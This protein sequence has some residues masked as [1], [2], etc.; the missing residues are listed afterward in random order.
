MRILCLYNNEC[1]L[2]LFEWLH[3]QGHET[4]LV[5]EKLTHEWCK[6]REIDL[7]VSYTYRYVLSEEILEILHYNA[8]NLHNSFLPWNR[9][10]D[11]NLW[12]LVEDVPR[13]VTLHYMESGLDKGAV[14]TQ[15]LVPLLPRD[16]LRSS[17]VALDLAAQMQ[18]EQ[19]F[20]W[21]PYWPQMKK[22][23]MDKGSYHSVEDGKFLHDVIDTYDISVEEFRQ[24]VKVWR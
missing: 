22:Y 2:P 8:V 9:G 12:S 7:A 15:R 5:S 6:N 24:R 20:Q 13:G 16:T 11:P 19:A 3:K 17:Y 23:S 14:I 10:S 1:A 21:Y 18:F 4:I